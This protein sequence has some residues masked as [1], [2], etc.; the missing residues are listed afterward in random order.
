MVLVFQSIASSVSD[1]LKGVSGSGRVAKLSQVLI[2][3]A[4][5]NLASLAITLHA[6]RHIGPVGFGALGL[7]IAIVTFGVVLLDSGVSVAL[8]R[9]YNS[10]SDLAERQFLIG[11]V[12]KGKVLQVVLVAALAYPLALVV[13]YLLPVLSEL[14]LVEVGI[15]SAALMSLWTSVRAMEQARRDYTTFTRYVFLYG[16][17]RFAA[18]GVMLAFHLVTPMSTILSLYLAPLVVLL[19]YTLAV[20]ERTSLRIDSLRLV[21]ESIALWGA[22]KYGVWVSSAAICFALAARAPLI[23]L[24]RRAS[25]KELGLYTAALTF[26]SG[27]G[28]IWDALSTVIVPEVS[29]LQTVEARLRFRRALFHKLPIMFLLLSGGLAVCLLAQG[30]L[31]GPAYRGSLTAFAVIGSAT[32]ICM[33]ISVNNNLVHAYGMPQLLTYMQLGRLVAIALMLGICSQID[34]FH[35]AVIYATALFLG[36]VSLFLCLH[37]R[38]RGES[39]L[40]VTAAD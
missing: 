16:A 37:R 25:L 17:F 38:V 33:C 21:R 27:F 15:V 20:R 28:L 9:N 35:V 3:N 2:A 1:S 39:S 12:L 8:V 18:Y 23:T 31:L 32:V 40:V 26:V 19:V 22:V 13:R 24:A 14:W 11:G 6:A 10:S 36:D 29:G 34:A 30:F 5:N 7:V 4:F